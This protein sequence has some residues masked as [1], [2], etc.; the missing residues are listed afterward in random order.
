M[1]QS[2][3][4]YHQTLDPDRFCFRPD[5]VAR[6]AHWLPARASDPNSI[7]L[8]AHVGEVAAGFLIGEVLDEIP[9]YRIKQYGF[10]HD[11]W[12]EPNF[13]RSGLGRALVAK[14]VRHFAA[15]GIE[16]IRGDT[17]EANP[18]ARAMLGPLGFI[19]ST[20]QVLLSLSPTAAAIS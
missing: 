2:V 6:Y 15:L 19:T 9:I 4:D 18:A 1:V 13:R 17:A 10:I 11:L 7:L 3:C 16:Q 12:V 5:V 20:R 8:L 14:A